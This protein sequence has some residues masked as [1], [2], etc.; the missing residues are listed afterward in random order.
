[1]SI[2]IHESRHFC[3]TIILSW[4][5][6]ALNSRLVRAAQTLSYSSAGGGWNPCFTSFREKDTK[7]WLLDVF[8]TPPL[9]RSITLTNDHMILI[10]L[11]VTCWHAMAGHHPLGFNDTKYNFKLFFSSPLPQVSSFFITEHAGHKYIINNSAWGYFCQNY[12]I[13]CLQSDAYKK[14]ISCLLWQLYISRW[15]EG[16][17]CGL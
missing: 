7:Q 5:Y 2:W 10:M 11:W 17:Q 9:C 4:L 8:L 15:H 1:M 12:R 13:K 16:G 14:S 6:I 3:F